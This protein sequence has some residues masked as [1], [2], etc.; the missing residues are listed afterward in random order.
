MRMLRFAFAVLAVAAFAARG[1]RA[2]AVG[3]EEVIDIDAAGGGVTCRHHHDWS[4]DTHRARWQVISTHADMFNAENDFA[5]LACSRGEREVFR[6]PSPALT[7]LW[8]SD[9]GLYVVGL[10]NV[11]SWNPIQVVVFETSGKRIFAA[12]I[13]SQESCFT[14]AEYRAFLRAH[15]AA[16]TRL[17][18]RAVVVDGKVYAEMTWVAGDEGAFDE[19]VKR[20]CAN[21]RRANISESVS[22]WVSWYFKAGGGGGFWIATE[23]AMAPSTPPADTGIA[24]ERDKAGAPIALTLFDAAGAPLRIDLKPKYAR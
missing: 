13:S 15:P 9:D 22:N 14:V 24:L 18:E 4:Y 10:S 8:V 1:A 19:L 7:K 6:S 23:G 21:H 16:R 3:Y 5:W 12:P 20:R 11:K 2:D 17:R